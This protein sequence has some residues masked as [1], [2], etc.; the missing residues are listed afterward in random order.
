MATAGTWIGNSDTYTCSGANCT[1]LTDT[2]GLQV[3]LL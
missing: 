2:A 1:E 3:T